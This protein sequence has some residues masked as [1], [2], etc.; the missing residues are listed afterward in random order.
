MKRFSVTLRYPA[1][2]WYAGSSVGSVVPYSIP[3]RRRSQN[4][5]AS[6]VHWR[7]R[8]D[9]AIASARVYGISYSR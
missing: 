4:P 6:Q 5:M 7:Q 3:N 9:S 8:V 1:P 2:W